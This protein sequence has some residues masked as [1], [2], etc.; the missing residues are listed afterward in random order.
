MPRG[1]RLDAPGVLHH[2]MARGV[3]RQFLFRDDADRND[4][5]NRLAG[6]STTGAFQVYAWALLPNHFHL[7]VRTDKRPLSRAMRSLLTGYA[8]TFNRRHRRSGHLFHN[9]Y[10]SIV[11]EEETYFLELIRYLHLN[12]LRA[13]IVRDLPELARYPYSGHS[14]LIGTCVYS[15]QA[16]QS[17]LAQFAPTPRRARLAYQAFVADGVKQGRRAAF[18]GGGLVRSAGGWRAVQELRRGREGY[19]SD[20]RV[21]GSSE[22]IEQ[23]RAEIDLRA[24]R[25]GRASSRAISL[26]RLIERVCQAEGVRVESISGGGRK[27]RLCRVREGIAYLWVEYLGH[28]GRQLAPPLGVQPESIYRAARRGQDDAE[29]WQG[30]LKKY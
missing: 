19:S 4:F 21:L 16:I 24:D 10:K 27:A 2:V 28:S 12:P 5:V 6:V 22:F 8:G 3:A 11:C 23:L 17:V 29:R 9:R 15:W 13:G 18:Q 25:A 1:P 20:E 30:L 14:A 7:L 26:E